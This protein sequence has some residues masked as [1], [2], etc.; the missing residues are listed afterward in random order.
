[1]AKKKVNIN[2]QVTITPKFNLGDKVWVLWNSKIREV[3]IKQIHIELGYDLFEELKQKESYK[4]VTSKYSEM[5]ITLPV[6]EIFTT[7]LEC[8][9]Y[10]TE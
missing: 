2:T 7:Q 1:M 6:S 9:N 10:L 5:S 4:L 3:Y 8:M